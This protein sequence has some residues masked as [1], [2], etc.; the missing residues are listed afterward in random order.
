MQTDSKVRA[1]VRARLAQQEK[2][3]NRRVLVSRLHKYKYLYLLMIPG[4]LWFL[5]FHLL[6]LYGISIAFMDYSPKTGMFSEFVGLYNFRVLFSNDEFTHILW[7]T[8]RI[9]LLKILFGFPMPILLALSI[10]AVRVQWFRKISQTISYLPNFISWMIVYTICV[11]LFNGYTGVFA[12]LFQKLGI[13]YQDPTLNAGSLIGFLVF[14]SVWKSMGMG[15]IIYLAALS[16][17]DQQL[18]EAASVDGANSF[19]KL[20]SITL[21][22][23]A[24]VCAVVLILNIGQLLGGDFEQIY[25]FQRSSDELVAVSEIFETYIYRN[26]IRANNFSL[27]AAMGIFQ[28]TFGAVLIVTSNK[29]ANKLGYEGIW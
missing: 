1:D 2:Q 12:S 13:P 23:I 29:I 8:V 3:A 4:A 24:P 17:I 25:L 21:P 18:Y 7:N 22:S 14:T 19:R 6:P 10:N 16:G 11:E 9:S 28:S 26:G 20:I 5:C 27:P 15:S